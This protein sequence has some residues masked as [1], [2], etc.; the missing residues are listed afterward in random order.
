MSLKVMA[1][2]TLAA[3]A[4]ASAA[5]A[6]HEGHQMPGAA[7]AAAPERIA[8]CSQNSQAVTAT[9]DAANVRIE[10]ARQANNAA[11]MRSAIGDLQVALAQ[12]KTQLAECVALS[13]PATSGM[14]G[15][16]GMDHSKMAMPS[17]AS[18][19]QPGSPAPA[20][21]ATEHAHMEHPNMPGMPAAG[22]AEQTKAP[23][24]A[25]GATITFHTKPAP[26]V[27]GDN[28]FEVTLKDR[29]DKPIADAEVSLAFYMPPM[30][31]MNMPAMRNTVKL[32]SAGNGVYR[33]SGT[34]GMAGDWDVTI[35]ATR[36]GQALGTKKVQL[37]AK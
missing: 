31:S 12:M 13:A 23:A 10:E 36:K 29:A 37:T 1:I 14:A 27:A 21:A 2:T 35:T 5:G 18:I 11:A 19:M 3:V 7:G 30:P 17:A 4:L 33:G 22:S 15:M 26:A 8:A 20:P 9:L 32:T 16:P 34:I 28:D 24:Q 25:G 6:Q